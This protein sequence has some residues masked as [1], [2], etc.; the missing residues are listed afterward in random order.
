MQPRDFIH[1]FQLHDLPAQVAAQL[2]LALM[3]LIG[4]AA[5]GA[6]TRAAGNMAQLACQ[7]FGGTQPMLFAN[8]TASSSGVALSAGMTIDAL[9]FH[10][11]F[12]PAKG[13]IGCPLFAA[14]LPVAH[15]LDASGL[16][17]LAALAMGYEFGARASVAQHATAPDYHTSGSWG[18]V[19]AAAACARLMGLD[20]TQTRH[21]LGIAEYHGPRSQMMRCI[22]HPTM[23]KD[24]SSWGAMA[25]VAAAELAAMGFTG[26][27]AITVED[28]PDHWADLGH[29]W[30][31]N[32][33]YYKN[34]PVCRWAQPPIEAALSLMRDH[35][36]HHS[37]ITGLHVTTFHAATR[38]ATAHPATTEEAQYSTTFP[39]AVAIVR[40]DVTPADIADDALNDA[41]VNRLSG[42]M[43]FS[44]DDHAN[45]VFPHQRVAQVTLTLAD[46][47]TLT[48][49]WHEP[50][51]DATDPPEASELRAKFAALTR[52]RLGAAWSANILEAI[53]TLNGRPFADLAALICQPINRDTSAGNSA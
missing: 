40:G 4:V 24:G 28:A 45:A 17:F 37:A 10:D 53:N 11:G 21:A 15:R 44:E 12:N 18:A 8:G 30:Q 3:D 7:Q 39:T 2:P 22:D 52:P 47:Q 16:D 14:I 13:H 51:W 6:E 35:S 32:Q 27:P 41:D 31:L 1:D 38:L 23:L 50:R 36:L 34:Y 20:A 9:D 19:T 5:G 25:G 43:T 26:A 46:G 42:L 49:D 33:Q 48:S 29:V